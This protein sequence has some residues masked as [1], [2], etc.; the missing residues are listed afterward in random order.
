MLTGSVLRCAA[1]GGLASAPR[2][3]CPSCKRAALAPAEVRGEGRLLSWTVIRRA[4]Q[5]F[6]DQAPYAVC[7]VDLD[8]GARATGRLAGYEREPALGARVR[9]VE[10]VAGVPIFAEEA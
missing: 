1:C 3:L 10:D 5:Q 6:R 7:V 8:C 2:L 4:P 9:C